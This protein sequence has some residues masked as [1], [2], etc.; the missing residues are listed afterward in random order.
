MGN[1]WSNK[2]SSKDLTYTKK[3][4][5]FD[6]EGIDDRNLTE[7]NDIDK[8]ILFFNKKDL[9]YTLLK[10]NV[11]LNYKLKLID[12]YNINKNEYKNSKTYK[13]FNVTQGGLYKDW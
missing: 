10:D 13:P 4:E 12:Y 11:D 1:F 5:K 7:N 8:I 2:N 9:L 6:F 3:I